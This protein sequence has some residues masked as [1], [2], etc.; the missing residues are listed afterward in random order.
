MS[1]PLPPR[2]EDEDDAEKKTTKN[3]K[4]SR[5]RELSETFVPGRTLKDDGDGIRA[6]LLGEM[7]KADRAA[8]EKRK[9][10]W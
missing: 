9:T 4:S 1:L 5:L 10:R 8:A 3:G 2:R 6:M 7:E